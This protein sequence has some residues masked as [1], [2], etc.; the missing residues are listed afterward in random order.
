MKKILLGACAG[1]TLACLI[2]PLRKSHGAR[3]GGAAPLS[4]LPAPTPAEISR[5]KEFFAVRPAPSEQ[6]L[7]R[8]RAKFGGG[9]ALPPDD[10]L[11]QANA[12][13]G[14]ARRAVSEAKRATSSPAP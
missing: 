4:A 14:E 6:E 13:M 5:M 3:E 12:A 2:L 1:F 11:R 9:L 7:E 8:L 10:L